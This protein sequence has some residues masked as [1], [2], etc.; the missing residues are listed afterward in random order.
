MILFIGLCLKCVAYF[1]NVRTSSNHI[2]GS[3]YLHTTHFSTVT[4]EYPARMAD[5][6][7]I[8]RVNM[9]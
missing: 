1:L 9:C 3:I 7:R 6:R 5:T 8:Q 2:L 4:A